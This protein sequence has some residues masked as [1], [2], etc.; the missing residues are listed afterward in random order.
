[1]S[2]I[3]S[4]NKDNERLYYGKTPPLPLLGASQY[5]C[6]KTNGTLHKK[7][8]NNQ[9]PILITMTA[10][11]LLMSFSNS[12]LSSSHRHTE[13]LQKWITVRDRKTD[14]R[15]KSGGMSFAKLKSN[16]FHFCL[17]L[18]PAL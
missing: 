12:S 14:K 10:T 17:I 6:N 13:S 3:W 1:V 5:V 16:S 7:V 15:W 2:G 18:D 11:N 4:V 9:Q 8:T